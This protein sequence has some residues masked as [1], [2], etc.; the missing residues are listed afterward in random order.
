MMVRA[1]LKAP[2]RSAIR[3]EIWVKLWGNL[4]F[5]PLSALTQSTLDRLAFTPG[6][7]ATARAMMVEAAQVAKLLGIRFPIDIDKRIDGA[8]EVGAHKDFDAAGSGTGPADGDRCLA[9]RGGGAGGPDRNADSFLPGDPGAGAR[10]RPSGGMLSRELS[11]TALQA[12]YSIAAATPLPAKGTPASFNP[13]SQPE[14]VP[15]RV[16]SLLLPR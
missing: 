2:V 3:D 15:S 1:G 8:G 9:G 11:R 4:A 16:R 13:I 7:R 5:N 12:K 10:T 14:S 6:L